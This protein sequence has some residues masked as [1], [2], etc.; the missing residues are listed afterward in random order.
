[1]IIIHVG[2]GNIH[3]ANGN[4]LA[5]CSRQ[6]LDLPLLLWAKG[7]KHRH[8]A[9]GITGAYTMLAV[10]PTEYMVFLRGSRSLLS[11]RLIIKACYQ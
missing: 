10:M 4:Q 9:G 2:I 5:E 7:M 8:L 1:M 6:D 3:V 11:C